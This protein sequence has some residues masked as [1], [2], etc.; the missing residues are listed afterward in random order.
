MIV[1]WCFGTLLLAV[2]RI[3]RASARNGQKSRPTLQPLA[4]FLPPINCSAAMSTSFLLTRNGSPAVS[5]SPSPDPDAMVRPSFSSERSLP[6]AFLATDPVISSLQFGR[7]STSSQ[8]HSS[9]SNARVSFERNAAQSSSAPSYHH[10]TRA[11]VH[12]AEPRPSTSSF[13][14]AADGVTPVNYVGTARLTTHSAA[15]LG[16]REARQATLRLGG[17]LLVCI[18]AFAAAM[19]FIAFKAFVLGPADAVPLPVA[20]L[21]VVSVALSGPLL[22][23]QV[24]LAEG[25]I[26]RP[27]LP[28]VPTMSTAND[29]GDIEH[30]A[31][32]ASTPAQSVRSLGTYAPSMRSV[33]TTSATLVGRPASVDIDSSSMSKSRFERALSMTAAHP[34]L[35]LLS[36]TSP[37]DS[38]IGPRRTQ[39]MRHSVDSSRPYASGRSTRPRSESVGSSRPVSTA[40]AF[41]TPIAPKPVRSSTPSS[42]TPFD[43]TI[44]SAVSQIAMGTA[45]S[46]KSGHRLSLSREEKRALQ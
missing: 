39:G 7:P 33:A 23:V 14:T 4:S 46:R 15:A 1:I 25:L 8:G 2:V 28:P 13:A 26:Y 22:A 29:G 17:H 18:L 31:S 35:Q 32:R 41:T 40:S 42:A 19:P 30:M 21:L 6:Y 27:R 38:A 45:S 34:K 10:V 16:R 36:G 24:A 9:G 37:A 3:R 20:I 44:G 43:R 12:E 5:P 11:D